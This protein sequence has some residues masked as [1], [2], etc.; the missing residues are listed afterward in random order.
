MP[1]VEF[2]SLITF[3][4]FLNSS[5]ARLPF[6]SF[7]IS[8]I[9]NSPVLRKNI[10]PI[11]FIVAVG[12]AVTVRGGVG[13]D[14]VVVVVTVLVLAKRQQ[15]CYYT[16]TTTTSIAITTTSTAITASTIA[17]ILIVTGIPQYRKIISLV[18]DLFPESDVF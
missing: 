6:H 10:E 15:N 3:F 9:G 14:D 7:F 1:L 5:S 17:A 18:H 2:L 11:K 13:D 16:T 4:T 12:V 8:V